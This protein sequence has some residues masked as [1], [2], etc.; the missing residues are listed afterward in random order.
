[1]QRE[2]YLWSGSLGFADY[3]ESAGIVPIIYNIFKISEGK[4][5]ISSIQDDMSVL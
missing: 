3:T 4:N 5:S 2:L 1:M